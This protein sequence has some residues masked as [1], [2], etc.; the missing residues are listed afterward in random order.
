MNIQVSLPGSNE[1]GEIIESRRNELA[2]ESI[3]GS[4]V[5]SDFSS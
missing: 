2:E 1:Q 5:V 3:P 4:D